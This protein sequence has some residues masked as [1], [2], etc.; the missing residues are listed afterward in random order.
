MLLIFLPLFMSH[1]LAFA[2]SN[3]HYQTSVTFPGGYQ[4]GDYIEFVQTSPVDASASGYYEISISYTRNGIAAAATHI[5]AISHSN[6]NKWRETGRVNSNAYVSVENKSFT[7][8]CNGALRQFR[9]RAIGTHGYNKMDPV[10]VKIKVRSINFNTSWT[11]LNNSGSDVS[12]TDLHP[13]TDQ[14]NVYTGNLTVGTSAHIALHA[15]SNGYVGIGTRNPTERLSVK[16]KI[17]AQEVKV[18]ADNNIN[19]PDYVFSKDYK[20]PSLSEVEKHIHEKGHLPEVPS[21]KEVEKEGI[22]LGANQALL[23]KKIEELTLYLIE[24]KH[25]VN[26]QKMK[27]DEQGTIIAGQ[28]RE[29]EKL[30]LKT[31]HQ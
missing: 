28:A 26:K 8:D 10:P 3:D 1:F 17:R 20:L 25:E 23:L 13:M 19:W 5:A 22:A 24:L 31:S 30:K 18:E 9:I 21:A 15:K 16:G 2:Q 27:N 12:V 14:W 4:I 29:I 7:I 6:Y 11:A